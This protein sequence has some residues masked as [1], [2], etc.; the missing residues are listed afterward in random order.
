MPDHHGG[1]A[2]VISE[3]PEQEYHLAQ[4]LGEPPAVVPPVLTNELRRAPGNRPA[5]NS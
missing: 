5:P 1:L 3:P 2:R 4:F